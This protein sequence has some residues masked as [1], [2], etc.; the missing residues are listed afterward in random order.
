MR[1]LESLANVLA[2]HLLR[3]D[4]ALKPRL[5]VYEGGLRERQLS[6]VLE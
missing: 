3:Q 2:V 1:S 5:S 4:S 6:Q